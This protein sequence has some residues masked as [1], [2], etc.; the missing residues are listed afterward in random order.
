M[1]FDVVVDDMV[2]VV[3]SVVVG[4]N[5]IVVCLLLDVPLP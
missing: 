5:V 1:G 4:V 3:C 2:L